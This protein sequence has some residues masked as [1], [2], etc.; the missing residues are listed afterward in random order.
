MSGK[1]KVVWCDKIWSLVRGC[2]SVSKGCLLCWAPR[3][4][5]RILCADRAR[6]RNSTFDGLVSIRQGG[7]PCWS[8]E[9]RCFPEELSKPLHWR[10][11]SRI[12]VASMGDLFHPGVPNEFIASVFGV[13]AACPQHQFQV[14]TKRPKRMREWFEW[15]TYE[16]PKLATTE[17]S[18]PWW[19]VLKC[20][21]SATCYNHD[22]AISKS[23]RN[24]AGSHWPLSNVW[25]GVSIEDQAT[26]DERI[27]ELLA[28][29]AAVRFVSAEPLLSEIRLDDLVTV[30]RCGE[31][32]RSSLECDVDAEDDKWRGACLDW[33]ICGCESGSHARPMHPDW[34]RS[35]R[36]QCVAAKVPFFFKQVMVNGKL[37]KM[38]EFDGRV[39]HQMPEAKP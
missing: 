24:L 20:W 22:F 27:P 32:H 3:M 23:G 1:S 39:W 11:P 26:S 9:V 13:M 17:P 14:L 21:Q 19:C 8:G 33:V 4:G 15:V 12:F 34:A 38:P 29:P 18:L 37:V 25:L 2:T 10:K 6:G 16:A 28:T 5:Y 7:R 35:L 31:D 30:R 36:D